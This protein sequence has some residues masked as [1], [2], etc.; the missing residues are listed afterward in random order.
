MASPNLL[1][2]L[3]HALGWAVLAEVN[4]GKTSS[5]DALGLRQLWA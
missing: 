1:P 5:E 4:E 3:A 2:V